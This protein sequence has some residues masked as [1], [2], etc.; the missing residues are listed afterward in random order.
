MDAVSIGFTILGGLGSLVSAGAQASASRKEQQQYQDQQRL[1]NIAALE[2]ERARREQLNRSLAAQDAAAAAMGID[3]SR[4]PSFSNIK[5]SDTAS[6][7]REIQLIRLGAGATNR[8]LGILADNAGTQASASGLGG[9]FDFGG[10][11][12]DAYDKYSNL[13]KP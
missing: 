7:D 2:D 12:S 3:I 6:A 9:L 8:R 10:S 1:N 5:A 13:K 11:L 4:S